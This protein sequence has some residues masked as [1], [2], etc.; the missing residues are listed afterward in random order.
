MELPEETD[1]EKIVK[2]EAILDAISGLVTVIDQN[3]W[4][5]INSVPLDSGLYTDETW[6]NLMAALDLPEDTDEEK[7]VK[8]ESVLNAISGLVTLIDQN[9]WEAINS[10]PLDSGLYTDES[11]FNLVVA[12]DLPEGTD[13]DKVVKTESILNAISELVTLID[14]NLMDAKNNVP[15][16]SGVYTEESWFNL[17]AALNLP[18]ET[19]G[20]KVAKAEAIWVAISNLIERES[21]N[22]E[23]VLAALNDFDPEGSEEPIEFLTSYSYILGIDFYAVDDEYEEFYPFA[24]WL[25][26]NLFYLRPEEGFSSIDEF[27]ETFDILLQEMIGYVEGLL[28]DVKELS[29][30]TTNTSI[31]LTWDNEEGYEDIRVFVNGEEYYINGG[32]TITIGLDAGNVYEIYVEFRYSGYD[33]PQAVTETIIVEL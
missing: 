20:E 2:T 26:Y 8:I 9:L 13:E 19:D 10:V 25:A 3:L 11:W 6:F 32:S 21:M 4:E 17:L 27:K 31:I 16:D 30:T 1:V 28:P 7:V 33:W 14:Q 22:P 23:M 15:W 18:E 29:Y 12:L 24:E 5:A